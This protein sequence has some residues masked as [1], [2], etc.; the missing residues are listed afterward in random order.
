MPWQLKHED[1]ILVPAQ[2]DVPSYR[3]FNEDLLTPHNDDRLYKMIKLEN[4]LNA[5]VVHDPDADISA[6]SMDVAIGH[7]ADPV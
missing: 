5:T 2:H 1:W 7:L 4:G 3:V 6:A